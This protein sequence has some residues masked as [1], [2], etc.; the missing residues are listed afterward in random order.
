MLQTNEV[1]RMFEGLRRKNLE[2]EK[3]RMVKSVLAQT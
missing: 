2:I 1:E 3:M